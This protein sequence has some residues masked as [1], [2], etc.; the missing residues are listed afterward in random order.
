MQKSF[1]SLLLSILKMILTII[2]NDSKRK[3]WKAI[4]T[5]PE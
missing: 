3:L 2:E 1:D 4:N 5:K